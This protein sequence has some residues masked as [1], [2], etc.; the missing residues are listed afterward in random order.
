MYIIY[1]LSEDRDSQFTELAVGIQISQ[2]YREEEKELMT[3]LQEL[4]Q[5]QLIYK[6]NLGLFSSIITLNSPRA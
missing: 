3:I 1:N 6:R 5:R 4:L 2:E